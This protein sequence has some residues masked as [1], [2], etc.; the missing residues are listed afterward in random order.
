VDFLT[1]SVDVEGEGPTMVVIDTD[2]PGVRITRRFDSF[3]G[4]HHAAFAFDE[5]RVPAGHVVGAA[6]EGRGRAMETISATRRAIAADC[7]GTSLWALELVD[8]HL[9]TERRD[10]RRPG[11]RE[12]ARLRYGELRIKTYAARSAVYRT[13]RLTDAGE[14]VVNETIAAKVL[15]TEVAGEVVDTAIQ[16]VGGESL[17][18]GHPLEAAHRRLRTLRLAEGES[19]TLRVNVARGRLDLGL[20]RL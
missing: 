20:G 2:T 7:V 17:I 4:T 14:N 12:R 1:A 19:D 3:D 18:V 15:A 16:L 10:G 8:E 5:A 6:G 13:A 11:D 9:S